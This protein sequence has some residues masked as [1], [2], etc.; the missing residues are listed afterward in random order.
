[1]TLETE[2]QVIKLYWLYEDELVYFRTWYSFRSVCQQ[3][4]WKE[5]GTRAQQHFRLFLPMLLNPCSHPGN[6]PLWAQMDKSVTCITLRLEYLN[7]APALLDPS[8]QL[9]QACIVVEKVVFSVILMHTT[10]SAALRMDSDLQIMGSACVLQ[11]MRQFLFVKQGREELKH[12]VQAS[13]F[14]TEIRRRAEKKQ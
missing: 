2:L 12:L 9:V 10:T 13:A 14:S 3:L 6:I 5:M 1:M 4:L 8:Q 7:K 11:S